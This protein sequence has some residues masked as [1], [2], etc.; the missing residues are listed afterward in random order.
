MKEVNLKKGL[1]LLMLALLIAPS[2]NIF[3]YSD[4]TTVN[5]EDDCELAS[6]L[7]ALVEAA[8]DKAEAIIHSLEEEG[9]DVHE[10]AERALERGNEFLEEAL[11]MLNVGDCRPASEKLMEALQHYGKAAQKALKAVAEFEDEDFEEAEKAIGLREAIERAYSF[12]EKVNETATDF[13]EKGINVTAVR[14]L[15]L[16]ANQTLTWAEIE[17]DDGNFTGAEELKSSAREMIGQ[18]MGLLQSMNKDNNVERAEEFLDKTEERLQELQNKLNEILGNLDLPPEAIEGI[19]EAFMNAQD[20][21]QVIKDLLKTG[22]LENALD[23]LDRV[24]EDSD[25]ALDVVD[26]HD[27]GIGNKLR[28]IEKIQ[29]KLDI[30]NETVQMLKNEGEVVSDLEDLLETARDKLEEASDI[31][32][33]PGLDESQIDAVED[34]ID[35][36]EEDVEEVD[37]ML[38]DLKEDI[39]IRREE[40]EDREE[41]EEEAGELQE[42]INEL[43]EEIQDLNETAKVLASEGVNVTAIMSLLEEAKAILEGINLEEAKEAVE[44]QM[45][46]AKE[47]IDEAEDLIEELQETEG[48]PRGETGE[49]TESEISERIEELEEELSSLEEELEELRDK[50]VNVEQLTGQIDRLRDII[51]EAKTSENPEELVEQ[52]ERLLEE[53]EDL[54]DKLG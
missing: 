32:S 53:I 12:L 33:T 16:E 17:L 42:E 5:T 6:D 4:P 24:L 11:E 34:L 23:E 41:H 20:K 14:N 29:A 18:A 10:E 13:E 8:R 37:D 3:A 51:E 46:A 30:L 26:E 15:L 21:I 49:T 25:E 47:L 9:T 27:H 22:D 44:N 48:E 45:D 28:S 38:D 19:N 39:D 50:Q 43:L 35:D 36:A 52:A 7:L 31:L 54:L 40:E 1:A 2:I